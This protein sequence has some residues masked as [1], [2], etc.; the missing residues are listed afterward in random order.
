MKWLSPNVSLDSSDVGFLSAEEKITSVEFPENARAIL[1]RRYL[2][3]DSSGILAESPEQ[4]FDRVSQVAASPEEDFEE[5]KRLEIL[6]YNLIASKRFFPNSPTFTGAGTPLGQLAACFVL[7]LA[8]DLG[9][10]PDGI[11]SILRSAALIQQSGGGNG[12]PFSN[13]RPKGSL[14]KSSNGKS[15]GP[16]GFLRVFDAAFGEIAQG[17]VRRGANMAVMSVDHPDVRDFITCKSVEG[18]FTNFN[19]SIALTDEFMKAVENDERYNLT[20][21]HNGKVAE[22][23]RAREIFDL[24]ISHAYKNGEPGVLFIDIANKYNP[25]PNLYRLQAT[26]PCGEQ[27]LGPYENCC[28]GS[29][30]LLPHMKENGNMDWGALRETIKLATHF[31]D[32]V[33]SAN[34]Y[35]P[36][37]PQVEQA[38]KRGR[39]VGLGIMGLAD[40]MYLAGVKYGSKDGL[41]F[42]GQVM[43]FVRYYAL[44]ESVTLAKEKGPFPAL[45]GSIYDKN[46]FKWQRPQPLYPLE[47]DFGRPS[48]NW[49]LMEEEIK[50]YG[51][52]NAAQTTIAPTGTIST[53]AG[54]EGYGCEPVFALAYKRNVYQAAGED[55]KMSLHY[56]SPLFERALKLAGIPQEKAQEIIEE[57]SKQGTCQNVKGIPQSIK[58]V[59][60]VSSDISPEEHV[61]TQACL[62]AFVD[63]S[64]SKTCNLPET[65]TKE[66]IANI[67]MLGWKLGCKGLTVYVTGSRKEV[68]LEVPKDENQTSEVDK[69]NLTTSAKGKEGEIL[70][71]TSDTLNELGSDKEL[72]NPLVATQTGKEKANGQLTQTRERAYKLKGATYK[73]DTPQ[74]KAFVVINSD[75]SGAPFE[76][77]VNVGKAGSDVA[78]LSEALGRLIS[79]WLRLSKDPTKTIKEIIV[80]L[81]GIGGA[82]SVGFGKNRVSSVPDAVAKVLADEYGIT[83]RSNGANIVE[84][85]KPE[86]SVFSHAD[87]CPDCGNTSLVLEEGCCKCYVCGFSMC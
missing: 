28:L 67:Y 29:I 9:K 47:K 74:G 24:I 52:R 30:N 13:L 82:R 73:V 45:S 26:N 14:V 1:E 2:L 72:K 36:A 19:I 20:D 3:K 17:G 38:A 8:D 27:W 23:P 41:D 12:F 86:V 15:S 85:E 83:V 62:Q 10:D 31:L 42:A 39:R 78:A 49:D 51:V 68:V 77:F 11:F 60:V 33:V 61:K 50:T 46:N 54:V 63:N 32:N 5:R 21:P 16:L 18:V 7:P 57:V 75:E 64:I 59:F 34:K 35:I 4:M 58:D 22:S 84:E 65:A 70:L 40:S 6:F 53:V 76:V 56:V 55:E 25:L 44:E 48:L 43:E 80:Q 66:D 69:A 79:G 37:V 81:I 71:K 87:V